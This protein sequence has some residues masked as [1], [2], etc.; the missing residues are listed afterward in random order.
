MPGKLSAQH[1]AHAH[2]SG[3][4]AHGPYGADSNAV[5]MEGQHDTAVRV[6]DR[7]LEGPSL[8]SSSLLSSCTTSHPGT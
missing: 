6:G 5:L 4:L 8:K 7:E 2:H 3:L 1:L